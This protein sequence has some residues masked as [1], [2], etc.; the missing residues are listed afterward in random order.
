MKELVEWVQ[1]V[2]KMRDPKRIEG[3]WEDFIQL[4]PNI[5]EKLI[6]KDV[7]LQILKRKDFFL[8]EWVL[9]N[10]LRLPQFLYNRFFN[11]SECFGGYYEKECS[12]YLEILKKSVKTS[13][14]PKVILV[15]G[16][17]RSGKDT[18]TNY[19]KSKLEENGYNVVHKSFA[20]ELKRICI[21]KFEL[22]YDRLGVF[23]DNIL[24]DEWQE[25]IRNMSDK[26]LSACIGIHKELTFTKD[27]F[28]N[29]KN[30]ISRSIMEIVGTELREEFV[31]SV[32]KMFGVDSEKIEYVKARYWSLLTEQDIVN[33]F[34]TPSDKDVVI[35]SDWRFP[36]EEDAF[37]DYEVI[38]IRMDRTFDDQNEEYE[39]PHISEIALDEYDGFDYTV[40]KQ[41]NINLLHL[42]LES[43][44]QNEFE[45]VKSNYVCED[46]ILTLSSNDIS[47]KDI[48]FHVEG[49]EILKLSDEGI[50]LH[51]KEI[52][53]DSEVVDGLREFLKMQGIM[54]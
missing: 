50:F 24:P 44:L 43:I 52:E 2:N 47:N 25:N 15:S 51:G 14:K 40:E 18:A 31:E 29:E 35:I 30:I 53:K 21:D 28:Y 36:A 33:D 5:D 42:E 41:R 19:I 3:I 11:D 27:S 6:S 17:M 26:N 34:E 23:K 38:K 37:K 45:D 16:K 22:M 46:V 32:G 49:K 10:E 54:K 7:Q 9:Y 48:I 1:L 20:S 39:T 13:K 12:V 8:S 4:L